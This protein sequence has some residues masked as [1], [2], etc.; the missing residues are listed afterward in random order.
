M[1]TLKI[2]FLGSI[3]RIVTFDGYVE[4]AALVADAESPNNL[5]I[6]EEGIV[7]NFD[8]VLYFEEI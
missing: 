3:E 1:I 4:L 6:S 2:T 5:L 8:N 7:I